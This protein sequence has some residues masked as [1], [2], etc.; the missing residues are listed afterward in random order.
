[1]GAPALLPLVELEK[2][3][4]LA[5]EFR[6]RVRFVLQTVHNSVEEDQKQHF[7]TARNARR[8]AEAE[9]QLAGTNAR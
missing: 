6:A 9:A 1:M 7:W 4:R 3:A 2:S 8:L 5:P